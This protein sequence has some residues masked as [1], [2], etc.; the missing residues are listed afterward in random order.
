MEAPNADLA[1]DGTSV[2]RLDLRDATARGI[3][4][5]YAYLAGTDENTPIH[6][7][8]FKKWG[9]LAGLVSSVT[10]IHENFVPK[11][12]RAYIH[13]MRLIVDDK[14]NDV[15]WKKFVL[16]PLVLHTTTDRAELRDRL[17]TL[18]ADGCQW[19][20]FPLGRFKHKEAPQ[21]RHDVEDP[22]PRSQL[23]N[24]ILEKEWTPQQLRAKRYLEHQNL[25]S[26]MRA[27][28]SDAKFVI[29]TEATL[30]KLRDKH[31]AA[32]K[33][34][35]TD[36]QLQQ[37]KDA[38]IE[39]AEL[40]KV[41][42]HDVRRV[43][44]KAENLKAP[45]L[46]LLRFEH[47]KQLIGKGPEPAPGDE[48]VFCD[49]LAKIIEILIAGEVPRRVLPAFRDNVLCP[50][51][52]GEQDIRPI[53][54]GALYRKIGS[55]ILEEEA[56]SFSAGHFGDVQDAMKPDAI[57]NIVHAFNF[58]MQEHPEQTVWLMDAENAFNRGNRYLFLHETLEH[59]K[60]MFPFM[61]DMYHDESQGFVCG[62]E[63]GIQG[64]T[65]SEGFHQ[66]DVLGT[67]AFCMT[68]Q[69]MLNGLKK[70]LVQEFGNAVLVLI[71]FFV[72]D[73]NI[74][75]PHPVLL[76]II[77]YFLVEGPTYGFFISKTK[78][79]FLLGK[80]ASSEDAELQRRDLCEKGF[81][82]DI[83]K[84]H[85]DN[86]DDD[87]ARSQAERKYGAKMLGSFIGH[88][89]YI[90]S[91][92]REY[93]SDDLHV[94]AERIKSYPDLQGR[95]ILFSRCWVH[96]PMHLLRTVP[97]RISQQL[98]S[99]FERMKKEI[100]M[101]LMG[102]STQDRLDKNVYN[103]CNFAIEQG[104]LGFYKAEEIAPAAYLASVSSFSR[105]EEGKSMQVGQRIRDVATDWRDDYETRHS[106][107]SSFIRNVNRM[108][109]ALKNHKPDLVDDSL[110]GICEW[111][112]SF[113]L[114]RDKGTV[115]SWLTKIQAEDRFKKLMEEDLKNDKKRKKWFVDLQNIEAGLWL[116]D[117]P[118][119]G[120]GFTNAEFRTALRHRLY[121]PVFGYLV[122]SRCT[123]K[124]RPGLDREGLHLVSGCN[125]EG[126]VTDTHNAVT[127]A[128]ETKLKW[129]GYVT[130]RE[131]RGTFLTGDE[132][133]HGRSD[134]SIFNPPFG[135]QHHNKHLLDIRVSS[136]LEGVKS[137]F[138][139]T[140]RD[141]DV[142]KKLFLAQAAYN[143]KMNKYSQRAHNSECGFTPIIFMSTGGVHEE[144]KKKIFQLVKHA[145]GNVISI[146]KHT[147]YM[148]TMRA[149]S[150]ALQK[151][152]ASAINI[153]TKSCNNRILAQATRVQH[154]IRNNTA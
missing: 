114:P 45:G 140:P 50:L 31:P 86:V 111:L 35:L 83:I 69:P 116:R 32:S 6:N 40:V 20:K 33:A 87:A 21:P 26:A 149:C 65:S 10:F 80:C 105:C 91:K 3:G 76:K 133:D 115:Q 96:K 54:M 46:D 19:H 7:I 28:M 72:D 102:Y 150:V 92:L 24:E 41:S 38:V 37:L 66:G 147:L 79:A 130:K 128:L 108:S 67:W 99:N 49:L 138:I 117:V 61:R 143:A 144:S 34:G 103:S 120:H 75:A 73:G 109:T 39:E 59:C 71:K 119:K 63:H 16:L 22:F 136:V 29:P 145:S 125:S 110:R 154:Q 74:S 146:P 5:R 60:F 126:K 23:D 106:L 104:G 52:K 151:G 4:G 122:G 70:F 141:N 85:P 94:A 14:S 44:R 78:G 135:S 93:V 55:K 90:G 121:L 82:E 132:N 27:L 124:H 42:L 118:K 43:I 89:A 101:S 139:K 131:E 97:P 47:L 81:S 25:S 68:I 142:N 36:A 58:R 107:V 13:Q 95:W 15:A 148:S 48:T 152:V 129:M 112:L 11:V 53:G 17:D 18:S 2:P 123:C 127:W 100:I 1:N 134:I 30:Q 88:P 56:K 153:R 8:S 57:A 51:P 77:D 84:I 137:G 98:F 12:R 113:V 62:F 9:T 64:I